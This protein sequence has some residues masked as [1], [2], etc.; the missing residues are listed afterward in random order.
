[1]RDALTKV[2]Q[3]SNDNDKLNESL[4]GLLRSTSITVNVAKTIQSEKKSS[5]TV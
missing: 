4:I 3:F 1:M 2:K 5:T